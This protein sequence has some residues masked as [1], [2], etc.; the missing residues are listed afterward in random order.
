MTRLAEAEASNS[1]TS[2]PRAGRRPDLEDIDGHVNG[3]Q[4]AEGGRLR[5]EGHRQGS[6]PQGVILGRQQHSYSTKRGNIPHL[7]L[8]R[9][10]PDTQ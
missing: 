4:R 3:E 6:F 7:G 9:A 5:A 1:L 10:V 8:R 2:T